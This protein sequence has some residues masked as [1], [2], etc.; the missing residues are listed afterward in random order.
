M[1]KIIF[2]YEGMDINI[3]CQLNDKIK[4]AID[5]F[6]IKINQEDNTNFYY[7]YNGFL[8]NKELT[9]KEQANFI[10]INRNEMNIIVKANNFL[11]T[12]YTK[13]INNI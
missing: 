7:L 5:K 3:Q 1:A 10:D 13:K 12:E 4:D 9:F 6:M 2:T 8:I 11:E